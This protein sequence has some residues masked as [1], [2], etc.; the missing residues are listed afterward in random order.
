MLWESF[1]ENLNSLLLTACI[2][3][4]DVKDKHDN[5]NWKEREKQYQW[6]LMFYLFK[7]N[8]KNIIFVDNSNYI[9]EYLNS[10]INK[11]N[12]KLNE[13]NHIIIEIEWKTLEYIT[14]DWNKK[15]HIYWYWYGEQEIMDFSFDNSQILSS[16][17]YEESFFKI[18]WRYIL[19]NINNIIKICLNNKNMFLKSI[20]CFNVITAIIKI[21]KKDYKKYLY[22]NVLKFY[23]DYNKDN[24]FMLEN[25]YYIKLRE[26]LFNEKIKWTIYNIY[27]LYN[28]YMQRRLFDNHPKIAKTLYIIFDFFKLN[29]NIRIFKLYD[30]L[31]YKTW[32]TKKIKKL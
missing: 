5:L 13:K 6:A 32:Y 20:H 2:H 11:Y 14:Y 8:F 16:L 21:Q 17:W 7:S 23:E 24:T 3:P 29:Q 30:F 10:L 9:L 27:Y 19:Y 31:F 28:W 12:T 18:T 22:S 25:I 1:M 15:S 26:I 4:K